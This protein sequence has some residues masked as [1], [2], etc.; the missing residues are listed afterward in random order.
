MNKT[1]IDSLNELA[2]TL[3]GMHQLISEQASMKITDLKV[4]ADSNVLGPY[5]AMKNWSINFTNNVLACDATLEEMQR[6]IN[7]YV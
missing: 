1:D 4:L 6:I 5:E 3:R 7:K 2:N